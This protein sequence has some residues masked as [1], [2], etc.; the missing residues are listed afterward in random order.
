VPYFG[1]INPTTHVQVEYQGVRSAPL[2]VPVAAAAPGLFTADF[3][4]KGQG[5]ILNQ[6]GVTKNSTASPASAGSIVILWGTGEGVTSPPGVDG[7][8]AIDVVPQPVAAVSVS[9]GGLPASVKYAGAAP[10]EIPGLFQINVQIPAGVPSGNVPVSVTIGSVVSQ[11]G[12]T[13]AVQ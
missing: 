6:D 13:L 9:I 4:G 12:V 1:A 7:R 5:A 8:P 10:G 2:Q 11:T 3:S